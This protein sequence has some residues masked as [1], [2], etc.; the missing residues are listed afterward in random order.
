MDWKALSETPPW[1]WPPETGATVLEIL[2]DEGATEDDLLCAAEMAGDA[3][4][5]DDALARALIAL[6]ER[7]DA[8]EEVRS[9]A[10]IS[11]GPLLEDGDLAGFEEPDDQPVSEEVF[12]EARKALRE[13]FEDASLPKKLR[14]R[15]LEASV[16]APEP[17]H[18]AAIREAYGSGD[19]DWKLTAVFAMR[20]VKGFEPQI[21]EALGS[22]DLATR[23]EAIQAAGSWE[24]ASAW[25]AVREVLTD[26]SPD[27]DLLLAAIEAAAAVS[28]E[29]GPGH[30]AE[31]ADSDDEDVS[32]A[33]NEALAIADT[34]LTEEGLDDEDD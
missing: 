29:E 20:W 11:L 4:L 22:D 27:Q 7:G 14:R 15:I 9:K 13:R 30:L 10:A 21:L 25:P 26:E 3:M 6:L 5:I 23:F 1:D 12:R 19:A 33:A 16:R 8:S 2:R 31:L 24:V 34:T 17:W 18:E 32:A 28:P